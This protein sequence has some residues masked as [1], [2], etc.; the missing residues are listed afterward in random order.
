[1]TTTIDLRPLAVGD[2]VYIHPEYGGTFDIEP[3]VIRKVVG[4]VD[5][6]GVTQFV[7]KIKTK[8]GIKQ[9]GYRL[10]P[11]DV[12]ASVYCIFSTSEKC[13]EWLSARYYKRMLNDFESFKKNAVKIIGCKRQLSLPDC[14]ANTKRLLL[15]FLGCHP[16]DDVAVASDASDKP[17]RLIN[18]A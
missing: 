6:K 1:M 18:N 7:Y 3:C 10:D 17:E 16:A 5:S 13:M 12:D 11:T 14:E 8:Y 15:E 9:N 4:Y 2:T